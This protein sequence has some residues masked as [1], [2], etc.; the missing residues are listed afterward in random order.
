MVAQQ[1]T[2]ELTQPNV[3]VEIDPGPLMGLDQQTQRRCPRNK[4]EDQVLTTRNT[5]FDASVSASTFRLNGLKLI[6][7]DGCLA[8]RI[9]T[10]GTTTSIEVERDATKVEVLEREC[11]E[12]S[13]EFLTSRRPQAIPCAH[14]A[15]SQPQKEEETAFVGMH[16]LKFM[17]NGNEQGAR[18]YSMDKTSSLGWSHPEEVRRRTFDEPATAV[19][20]S[21]LGHATPASEPLTT[22]R[23]SLDRGSVTG[24]PYP[25]EH[26]RYLV[27]PLDQRGE[28]VPKC[29]LEEH[30]FKSHGNR[31]TGF[32][33]LEKRVAEY[34]QD[35]VYGGVPQTTC[36]CDLPMGDSCSV[37][38]KESRPTGRT[39][40]SDVE[41]PLPM[42]WAAGFKTSLSVNTE[43]FVRELL[44]WMIH[45]NMMTSQCGWQ[46]PLRLLDQATK[47]LLDL[48]AAA[49]SSVHTLLSSEA[50]SARVKQCTQEVHCLLD[51]PG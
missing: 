29:G 36:R 27:F 22:M 10:G 38:L 25:L 42:S 5:T 43:E 3:L 26:P 9:A 1:L 35:S 11:A 18:Q 28:L 17:N 7:A 16:H 51:D 13:G 49:I 48:V 15:K 6:E 21:L 24:R 23:R 46:S 19:V 12:N 45:H 40:T 39:V 4:A 2:P 34:P 37:R 20:P 41:P 33:I 50:K 14:C 31:D 32:V 30:S 8:P 44:V 47:L